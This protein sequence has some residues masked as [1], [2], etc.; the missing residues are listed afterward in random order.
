[1]T[2]SSGT[3][4]KRLDNFL[5]SIILSRIYFLSVHFTLTL[6]PTPSPA[7]WVNPLQFIEQSEP[8]LIVYLVQVLDYIYFILLRRNNHRK[9]KCFFHLGHS[10]L[11][12]AQEALVEITD[13]ILFWPCK[14]LD[15][16]LK[17]H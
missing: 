16:I 12:L 14:K 9:Q 6:L 5:V 4:E 1:M 10:L 8:S 11:Y 7:P 15:I 13:Y 2:G 3:N 17:H